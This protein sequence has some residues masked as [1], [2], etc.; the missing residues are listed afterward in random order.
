[1][2][3]ADEDA[4]KKNERRAMAFAKSMEPELLELRED[5]MQL[6]KELTPT[7]EDRNRRYIYQ[8]KQ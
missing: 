8:G 1:M 3:H 6:R 2:S 5:I 4:G 7:A